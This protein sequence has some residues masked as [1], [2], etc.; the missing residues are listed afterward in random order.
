MSISSSGNGTSGE[1]VAA[2]AQGDTSWILGQA[3]DF[4]GDAPSTG[5]RPP[6]LSL[7]VDEGIASKERL[8]AACVE[9]QKDGQSLG[10][11]LVSRG[12]ISEAELARLV[13]RQWQLA[14]LALSMIELD[15]DARTVMPREEC[16]RLA[17]VP[18]GFG[19]GVPLVAL[20]EPTEERLAGVRTAIGTDCVFVVVTSSALAELMDQNGRDIA[21][22]E[23][24][25]PQLLEDPSPESAPPI[26]GGTV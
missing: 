25:A 1:H 21:R 10:E 3:Q 4:A 15:E 9:A 11:A 12:W 2:D 5:N 23:T 16:V 13:A 8:E 6:L 14:F 19:D 17:A 24:D 7:L 22:Q 18:I 20:A 26:E